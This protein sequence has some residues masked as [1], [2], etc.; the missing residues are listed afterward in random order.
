[1]EERIAYDFGTEFA[2][3]TRQGERPMTPNERRLPY[4]LNLTKNLLYY[5]T[6]YQK[7]KQLVAKRFQ[8]L[9]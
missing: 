5:V 2:I 9:F 7:A 4:N 8:R 3:G 6:Y 1:M